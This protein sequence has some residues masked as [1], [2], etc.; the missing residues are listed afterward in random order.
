LFVALN[1][2]SITYLLI[3]L[4]SIYAWVIKTRHLIST[5]DYL[6]FSAEGQKV[7]FFKR[8]LLEEI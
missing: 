6:I 3:I 7:F 1:S 5:L 8:Q 2:F 4:K